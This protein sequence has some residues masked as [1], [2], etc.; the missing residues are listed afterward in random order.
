MSTQLINPT[1]CKKCGGR[2]WEY[3][4]Y[5]HYQQEQIVEHRCIEVDCGHQ[6]LTYGDEFQTYSKTPEEVR[7]FIEE[8]ELDDELEE[9][10]E[11]RHPKLQEWH[12][13]N[14]V[15]SLSVQSGADPDEIDSIKRFMSEKTFQ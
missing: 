1:G 2:R 6:E 7:E 11:V 4:D 8:Y 15:V 3:T 14:I 12:F 10:E 9:E 5:D 13:R